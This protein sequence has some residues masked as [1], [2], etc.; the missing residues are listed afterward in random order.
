M[1]KLLFTGGEYVL[2]PYFV[3]QDIFK[4]E[5]SIDIEVIEG[6]SAVRGDTFILPHAPTFTV[7]RKFSSNAELR[8]FVA[9]IN[10]MMPLV[11]RFV[12]YN[13]SRDVQ[14]AVFSWKYAGDFLSLE[15]KITLLPNHTY[16]Y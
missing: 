15:G 2:T 7:R 6:Q 5:R 10:A 4:I 9:S 13:K 14:K 16:F 3:P 12:Y 11:Y 8:Q 1:M